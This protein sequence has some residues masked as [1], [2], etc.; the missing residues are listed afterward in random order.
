MKSDVYI[1]YSETGLGSLCFWNIDEL[2]HDFQV[3]LNTGH[4]FIVLLL[5]SRRGSLKGK[6]LLQSCMLDY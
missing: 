1:Q 3:F 5:Y 2:Q 6:L 4:S